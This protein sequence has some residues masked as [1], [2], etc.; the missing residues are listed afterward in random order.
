MRPSASAT[1]LP[2]TVARP[3][4]AISGV[5]HMSPSHT[6]GQFIESAFSSRRHVALSPSRHRLTTARSLPLAVLYL[7]SQRCMFWLS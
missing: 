3:K 1:M 5:S 7:L 2:G 6:V 4:R